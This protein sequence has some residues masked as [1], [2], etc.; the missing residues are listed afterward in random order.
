M[1]ASRLPGGRIV[2]VIMAGGIGSRL[3]PLS[4]QDKPKQFLSIF[5]K[6]SLLQQTVSRVLEDGNPL[7]I[8]QIVVVTNR[9]FAHE[10]IDQLSG[11]SNCK[12]DF[13]F[14][15]AIRNTGPA[16]AAASV[17]VQRYYPGSVM[18]MLAADHHITR[19]QEFRR[20][21]DLAA[22][23]ASEGPIVT[24]GIRPD[25]PETGYGYIKFD[26]NGT[27]LCPVD[28]FVEKPDRKTAA[29]WVASGD[30][31]W[32]SGMFGFSDS[33]AI[34]AYG[35]YCPDVLD[36]AKAAYDNASILGNCVYLS[37]DDYGKCRSISIDY[38][39]M[40]RST[41][42]R[43]VPA[44][45]GWS[46]VG[47]WTQIAELAE[48][49]PT[50]FSNRHMQIQSSGNHFHTG[51]KLAVAI[52]VDNLVVV[53]TPD[54]ILVMNREHGQEI[55]Q[56]YDS[57][58]AQG[59]SLVATPFRQMSVRQ[60]AIH[61]RE[62][63]R[64][65]L[66]EDALPLWHDIGWDRRNG[67]FIESFDRRGNPN[68]NQTRR[69]RVLARQIY[70]FSHVKMLGWHVNCVPLLNNAIKYLKN[71]GMAPGG[72]WVHSLS[73]NGDTVDETVLAYDQAFVLFGLSW[74]YKATGNADALDLIR[75]TVE[76][77]D[78]HLA[79][80]A[81]G[82]FFD[83]NNVLPGFSSLETKR[84]Q[85]EAVGNPANIAVRQGFADAGGQFLPPPRNVVKNLNPHMHMLEAFLALYQATGDTAY[86]KRSAAI[87]EP[88]KNTA[89]DGQLGALPEIFDINLT[90]LPT[91]L[92]QWCE[93]GHH[94]EWAHL[95]LTYGHFA[96]EDMSEQA[97][98][99]FS[100]AE[101][102]GMSPVTGLAFDKLT[103]DGTAI[104]DTSRLWP[105]LERLRCMLALRQ[106]GMSQFEDKIEMAVQ[107]I[108]EAYLD[109]APVGMWE[110]KI[111]SV[112]KVV[113]NEI[114]QSSFYHLVACFTDYLGGRDA[115]ATTL[116]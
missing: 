66:V 87:V 67:G 43:V 61:N 70:A 3:W 18:L 27:E 14:E 75:K 81:N 53:D 99:L 16:M 69:L 50:E 48:L 47:G 78:Q 86:M 96:G 2:P 54:A 82:G 85:F 21:L 97:R 89:L 44:T 28:K 104:E 93:P 40:E 4:R 100:F 92:G 1:D 25:R 103:P 11:F 105:Q 76:Y 60:K 58:K 59:S 26:D 13:I 90:P 111:D 80:T 37:E 38:A 84:L 17:H 77:V 39:I 32:N 83:D 41:N 55:R 8:Q 5:G 107:N 71:H 68:S 113:S 109:P 46:D 45:I 101:A 22:Q 51:E 106:S 29:E 91:E 33:S 74:A 52:G 62:R 19:K 114:P 79:D 49:V 15:P 94:F 24:F 30:Y 12:F 56:V 36:L 31:L 73:A 10:T 63:I 34:N 64:K 115:D 23:A 116:A 102:F 112:G 72:G 95:L 35:D 98:K 7:G 88:L 6:Q 42:I 20:L 9:D 108:F 110:D 65:W 57:L